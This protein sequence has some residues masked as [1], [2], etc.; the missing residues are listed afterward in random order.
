[1]LAQ[2]TDT[3]LLRGVEKKGFRKKNNHIFTALHNDNTGRFI[4]WAGV[5]AL[6]FS[7]AR[8]TGN[9]YAKIHR[10]EVVSARR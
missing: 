8:E 10:N 1:M 6:Q 9:R 7:L 4:L 3:S 5:L 2:L